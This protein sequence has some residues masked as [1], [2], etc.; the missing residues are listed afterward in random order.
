MKSKLTIGLELLSTAICDCSKSS[1]PATAHGPGSGARKIPIEMRP[2]IKA[3]ARSTPMKV[4]ARTAATAGLFAL[5]VATNG[6]HKETQ[7]LAKSPTP[8]HLAEVTLYASPEGLRYS[9]SILPFAQ[10]S[11]SFKSSGYVTEI[12]Q[13]VGADGRRRDI[14]TGDFVGGGALLAQIRQQDLKNQL[15]QAQAELSQAEAQHLV[16]GQ[17]NERAKMLYATHSLTKPDF[18]QAQARFDSTLG[19]V[20]Q[21]KA[22]VRQAQLALEDSDLKA[23]F[24]GYILARNIELGD[25]ATPATTAFTIDDTGAVK[26]SFGVPEYALRHLRLGQEFNIH[27]QDN[28]K[29]YQGR[30]TSISPSAD[31][32][33]RVFTVEVTVSNPRGTLKPGMIASISLTGVTKPPVPSVPLS[34][35]VSDTVTPNHYA[36]FVPQEQGGIWV[37]HVREVTLGETQES[38]VAVDGVKPGEKVVVVGAAQLKDGEP[39]QVIP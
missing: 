29:D 32:K 26:V 8:V 37:A 5:I 7:I 34:A 9:A 17:D 1:Q 36:V 23:P 21:A 10:A 27:L 38:L 13:V 18:D 4:R 24:S 15:D 33:N 12:Q 30:V 22:A 39:I 31:E 35:I 2:E 11:L 20:N 25:L 16:A 3:E 6:C 28:P 19:A 14:G